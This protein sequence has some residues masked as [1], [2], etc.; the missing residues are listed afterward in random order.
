ME[1]VII[2]AVHAGN[3]LN[4]LE[5]RHCQTDVNCQV[6]GRIVCIAYASQMIKFVTVEDCQKRQGQHRQVAPRSG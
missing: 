2:A 5:L 6:G 3:T 4:V 1:E